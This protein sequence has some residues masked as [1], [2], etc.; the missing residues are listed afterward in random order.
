MAFPQRLLGDDE[1]LVLHQH[2]HW[3]VLILPALLLPVIVGAAAFGFAAMPDGSA[4]APARWAV[5]GV[6]LI[7]LVIFCLI[8]WLRWKT[9]HFILTDQRLV[10]RSGI[11]SRTGR[12]IPLARINDVTFSHSLVE[13]LLRCGRL[14]VESGGE[15]GQVVLDDVARVEQVQRKIAELVEDSLD[16]GRRVAPDQRR[17]TGDETDARSGTGIGAGSPD[18]GGAGD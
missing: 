4:Q 12:D 1:S 15:R 6:A 8:P 13:R 14:M 3:K 5:L 7:A 2:Q 11:L 16:P 10:L 9:T 17:G 18:A